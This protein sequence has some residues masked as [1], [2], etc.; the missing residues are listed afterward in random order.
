L[1]FFALTHRLRVCRISGYL[2][3]EVQ[4]GDIAWYTKVVL[5]WYEKIIGEGLWW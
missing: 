3:E 5:V 1:L 2:S 4:V